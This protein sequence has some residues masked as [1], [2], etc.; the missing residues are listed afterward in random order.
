MPWRDTSA[1]ED[2]GP[3]AWGIEVA[4][5]QVIKDAEIWFWSHDELDQCDVTFFLSILWLPFFH[6][7]FDEILRKTFARRTPACD[8][9]GMVGPGEA[10]S[11]GF[12]AY[13]SWRYQ[14]PS[15]SK[16][17]TAQTLPKISE[18]QEEGA[19]KHW[20]VWC[21]SGG[22]VA[23]KVVNPRPRE[24]EGRWEYWDSYIVVLSKLK[25]CR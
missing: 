16:E 17:L 7:V 13:H 2:H 10:R 24:P 18:S 6:F 22:R 4:P 25:K 12:S 23:S 3:Q 20:N 8:I 11:C 19:N 14:F 21:L 9:S 5:C 15:L 1:G